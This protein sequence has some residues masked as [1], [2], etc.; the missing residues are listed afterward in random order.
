MQ[1]APHQQSLR[2]TMNAGF[3]GSS[4]SAGQFFFTGV[5]QTNMRNLA[6]A[7]ILNSGAL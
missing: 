6:G 1:F 5:P 2:Q 7:L 3:V 4:Q